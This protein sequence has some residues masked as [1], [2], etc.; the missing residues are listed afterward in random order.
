MGGWPVLRRLR[1]NRNAKKEAALRRRYI[2]FSEGAP[3]IAFLPG[4]FVLPLSP[5]TFRRDG[6]LCVRILSPLQQSIPPLP[7]RR[8]YLRAGDF[9]SAGGRG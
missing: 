8:L 9:H 7:V 6:V 3:G 4:G 5:C 1:M 2:Y